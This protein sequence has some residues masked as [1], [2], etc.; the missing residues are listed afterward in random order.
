L[1]FKCPRWS[2]LSARF[3]VGDGVLGYVY[4]TIN[5]DDEGYVS[6][7]LWKDGLDGTD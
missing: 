6:V 4:A 5:E 1:L 3:V 7:S 2:T